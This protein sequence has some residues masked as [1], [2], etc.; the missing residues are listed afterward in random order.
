MKTSQISKYLIPAL[1]LGLTLPAARAQPGDPEGPG[2]KG[3]PPGGPRRERMMEKFD[4]DKDGQL[5]ESERAAAK[6]EMQARKATDLKDYDKDGNGELSKAEREAMFE[7]KRA[8]RHA[9]IL[10]KYDVDEDGVLSEEERATVREELG[11]PPEQRKKMRERAKARFDAD[12]DGVLSETER[13]AAQEQMQQR[14]GQK[15]GKGRPDAE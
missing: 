10:E 9:K 5:S 2:R 15:P 11:P 12:G 13:A 6:A 1:L 3:P 8:E 14:K 7:A 4:A